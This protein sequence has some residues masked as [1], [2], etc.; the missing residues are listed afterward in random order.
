M[1]E[2]FGVLAAVASSAVGG[3]AAGVTRFVAK[4]IDP[5]ALGS[6]RFGVGFMLLAPLAMA[7]K[8]K[9][10]QH[11]DW[12]ATVGLGLLFFAVFPVLFNA[13]LRF[14]TASRGALALSTLP[15]LTM[16]AGAL[17][18]VE[19]MSRRKSCGVLLAVAGV[20]TALLAG[21]A[22]APPTAWKGDLLMIGAS[23]CMALYSVWSRPIIGR[24]DPIT[25]TAM[26]MGVG[27]FCLTTISAARGSFDSVVDFG[28]P[29]WWA[30]AYLG[31]FGGALAFYL[32]AYALART[33]PTRVAVSVTVSPITAALVGAFI[34]DEAIRWNLLLGLAAVFA[35]IWTA[36]TTSTTTSLKSQQ[37]RSS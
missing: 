13:S 36:T 8:A 16:V 7:R 25:F 19:A 26:A 30:V 11:R 22:Y 6:L 2:V 18:G 14:T 27:A 3:A 4:V 17:L 35:G 24:S 9:W 15:L 21:L 5:L 12:P 10:P 20:A 1:S 37:T 31:V 33:T 28:W 34:L 23:G 32:W 29:Q